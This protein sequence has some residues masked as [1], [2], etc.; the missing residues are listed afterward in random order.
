MFFFDWDIMYIFFLIDL[1]HQFVL[2]S[3]KRIVVLQVIVFVSWLVITLVGVSLLNLCRILNRMIVVRLVASVCCLF[4]VFVVF[5]ELVS[6]FVFVFR[7][8]YRAI[9]VLALFVE[10]VSVVVFVFRRVYCVIVVLV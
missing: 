6:V 1:R 2:Y 3:I 4:V 8:V 10:M 9:V 7:L 5:V